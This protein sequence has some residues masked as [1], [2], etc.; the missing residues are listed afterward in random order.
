MYE[1]YDLFDSCNIHFCFMDYTISLNVIHTKYI[2][3]EDGTYVL[4]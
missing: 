3:D 1:Q 2:V 4:A